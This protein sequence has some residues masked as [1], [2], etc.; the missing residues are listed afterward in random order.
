MKPLLHT[1][2]G[3]ALGA[4]V[5]LGAGAVL[6]AFVKVVRY[7]ARAHEAVFGR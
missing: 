7:G 3:L 1:E 4:V 2:V 5:V 6:V